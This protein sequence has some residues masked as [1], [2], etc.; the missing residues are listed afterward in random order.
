MQVA[1]R[2]AELTVHSRNFDV[3]ALSVTYDGRSQRTA[4]VYASGVDTANSFSNA[5]G[6]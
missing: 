4:I 5:R 2:R 1:E 6:S 3:G